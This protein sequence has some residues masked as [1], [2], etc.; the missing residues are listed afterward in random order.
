MQRVVERIAMAGEKGPG[1]LLID[2]ELGMRATAG[3]ETAA[4]ASGR[5]PDPKKEPVHPIL[6]FRISE[7]FFWS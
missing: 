3:S 7:K 2:N 6:T 4:G 1:T 5:Y